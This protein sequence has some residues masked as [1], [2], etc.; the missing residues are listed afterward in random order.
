MEQELKNAYKKVNN[1]Y[2][3]NSNSLH[4][5]GTN[6]KKLETAATNQI[7]NILNLENYEIIYTSG[8]KESYELLSQN[9]K[10]IK[11][12][13]NNLK[14][15]LETTKETKNL[16]TH[17]NL[18][19]PSKENLNKYDFITI[20]DQIPFFGVLIKRKNIELIPLIHGGKSI[21]K[22]RAGTT[23][24]PLIV[25]MSKLIKTKYKNQK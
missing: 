5:L 10:N 22:Y 20:E 14:K 2:F 6:T 18:T 19:S 16:K 4:K 7:L 17:I 12:N 21:T 15:L 24:T 3:A 13:D 9:Y 23:P 25:I 1:E 8:N 11:T